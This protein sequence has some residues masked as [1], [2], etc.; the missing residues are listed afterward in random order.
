MIANEIRNE[1][2]ELLD[3]HF[4]P[5]SRS[6]VLVLIA[7]GVTGNMDR[8]LVVAMAERLSEKGWPCLRFSFSGNGNSEGKFVDSTIS[9][10][11]KDLTAVLGVIPADV[12]II[13]VGHSM[14][15]AVGVLTAENDLRIYSLVSLAGMTHTAEFLQREFGDQV[16]GEGFMW[17]EPECPLSKSFAED[18]KNIHDTLSAASRITQPWL[19]IHGTAD[20]VVPAQDGVDAHAAAKCQKEWYPVSGAGHSFGEDSY[21]QLAE[22]IDAWL[23]SYVGD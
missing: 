2:G 9:K 7:H 3:H 8:P 22:K 1:A 12:R 5:G 13:Y 16:P 10:E 21:S 23:S 17:D 20:D 19:F 18:M 15:A 6:E 11:Q 4:H 14:G